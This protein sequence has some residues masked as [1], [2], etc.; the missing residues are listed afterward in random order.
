MSAFQELQGGIDAGMDYE[1]DDGS[2]DEIIQKL[3]NVTK[4]AP[5]A[6]VNLEQDEILL[7]IQKV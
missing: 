1:E 7:I 3:L 2:V 6:M 5:G 4:K